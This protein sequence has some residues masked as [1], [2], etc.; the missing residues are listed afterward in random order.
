MTARKE[1]VDEEENFEDVD[2]VS[3]SKF[4]DLDLS[5]ASPDSFH[6]EDTL[7]T[8]RP[9]SQTPPI[10]TDLRSTETFVEVKSPSSPGALDALLSPTRT[11]H[12]ARESVAASDI[13]D[14][15]AR[16]S[17]VMLSSARQSLAD[18]PEVTEAYG[19]PSS[20]VHTLAET[21]TLHD[22][23]RDTLDGSELIRLVHTNRVHKKTASNSTIVSGIVSR[24]EAEG[25]GDEST[26]RA[27]LDGKQRLNEAFGRRQNDEGPEVDWTFWGDVVSDYQAFAASHP[28]ELAKAIERGI[29]KSLRGMIW[30]LMSASKDPDLE[31]TYLKLL[32]DPSPHEK[33]I[34][35]DLGRT[36]PH[37]AFFTEG[38][39]IGQ[40]NLFNVLKAYSLYD[41]SVGYCQGLPFI[42]AIL[43]LNMPDEEAFCLLVRLMHSYDLRGHFLPEM[44]KLQQ[45]MYDRLVEELL[46]VLHIH[47][48]RQGVKSSMYCSQWFLTMFSY[49]FPLSVV[50]RIYDNVLASG[51]EAMFSF[52]L[53]LLAKNEETLLSL[54]FDQLLVFLNNNMLDVYKVVDASNDFDG[55]EYDINQFVQDAVSMNITPFMLDQYATEYTELVRTRDAHAIEM[56]NLRNTNRT[57]QAQ[58]NSLEKNLAQLNTEHVN[59]LNELV[60]ARLRHEELESELVRY[61]LLYAEAMHESEDAQSNQRLSRMSLFSRRTSSNTS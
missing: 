3:E 13:T 19:D 43:L 33:A 7:V 54:K 57:L 11:E 51:V 50:F 15:D 35:R 14:D 10:V 5:A 53:M 61:K 60:M 24:A 52:S 20:P 47:F 30:Q 41:S 49:K 39:G 2:D 44:P 56:D 12:S 55:V 6:H 21:A 18:V 29:P 38:Q 48:I 36:F 37:H 17:T 46:P 8:P 1:G 40:E 32:K 26:H 34:Y 27:S 16:F 25:E 23:R 31:E 45:R 22:D 4:E 9:K 42:V 28:E 58:V 59:V